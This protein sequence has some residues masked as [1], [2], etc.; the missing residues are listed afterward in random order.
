M[1]KN[2]LKGIVDFYNNQVKEQDKLGTADKYKKAWDIF[3]ESI[4]K[5]KF[6]IVKVEFLDGY[7]IFG[8]GTNSVVHFYIEEIPG[9]K[10]GIW[11]NSEKNQKKIIKGSFFAQYEKNIDKFKPSNSVISHEFSI[12]TDEPTTYYFYEIINTLN[13]MKNEPELA[14]CRDY[15]CWNY[16][17]EYHTREEA[18]KEFEKYLNYEKNKNYYTQVCDSKIVDWFKNTFEK[19]LKEKNILLVDRGNSI[20]PRYEIVYHCPKDLYKK[21][22]RVNGFYSLEDIF[23]DRNIE[24]SYLK[25]TEECEKISDKY[26]FYWFRP[27]QL[28]A[29]VCD[30]KKFNEITKEFKNDIVD[31]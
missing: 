14:F 27:I 9:W 12:N 18:K 10:F 28:N 31:I 6:N 25:I 23:D 29:L 17:V 26:E 5:E 20:D 21:L 13:F 7:F 4:T 15:N 11:W 1:S 3:S 24:D 22:E 30:T 8:S 2:P 19:E 16:N